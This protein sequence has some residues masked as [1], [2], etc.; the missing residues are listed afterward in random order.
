MPTTVTQFAKEIGQTV[1]EVI[2]QF[3]QAGIA[4]KQA[5]D[6]VSVSEKAKFLGY[7]NRNTF[8]IIVPLG[9]AGI[10]G[11]LAGSRAFAS[12]HSLRKN[13]KDKP[14]S[15]KSALSAPVAGVSATR[16]S[17]DSKKTDS[18]PRS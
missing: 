8:G 1:P 15:G 12:K 16:D 5:S 3:S 14:L 17:R 11:A 13:I 7:M 18:P 4:G 9:G 2:T 10:S 6:Q